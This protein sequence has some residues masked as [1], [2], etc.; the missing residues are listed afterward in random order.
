MADLVE[1]GVRLVRRIHKVFNF[2]HGE[3]SDAQKTL[4]RRNLI[5]ETHADLSR[6]KGHPAIVILDESTEIYKDT[7]GSLRTQVTLILPRGPNLRVKHQ[8]E[9]NWGW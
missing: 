9:R 3:F 1:L 7:L 5:P 6:R 8:V 4:P 2:G